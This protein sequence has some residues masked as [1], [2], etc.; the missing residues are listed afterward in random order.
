MSKLIWAIPCSRVIV[1]QTTNMVS[2]IDVLDGAFLEKVPI[3]A[4]LTILGTLW[5][6]EKDSKLEVRIRAYAPDGT[7]L[8]DVSADPLVYEPTHK[9]A[10]VNIGLAGF[11]INSPGPYEFGIEQK[12]AGKWVEEARIL[13]EVE[14]STPTSAKKGKTNPAVMED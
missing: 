11:D 2:Y 1:D 3:K 5:K 8:M 10:R 14:I 9:R 6:R 4:P 13:F 12:K 7:H